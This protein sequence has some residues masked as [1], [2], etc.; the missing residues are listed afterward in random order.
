MFE[1]CLNV[2]Q[3]TVIAPNIISFFSQPHMVG[4]E[5]MF[6]YQNG[7]L[8]QKSLGTPAINSGGTSMHATARVHTT[9]GLPD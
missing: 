7:V 4:V 9:L 8:G 6:R 5:K 1:Y 2:F 3:L